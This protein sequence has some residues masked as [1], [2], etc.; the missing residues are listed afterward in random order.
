M[1]GL[2]GFLQA[3]GGSAETL[4]E[5]ASAM[6]DRLA[7]RGPDDAGAWVDAE[8]GIALGHRRLSIL[9]LTPEGHQPMLS[10]DGRYVV[11]FNG[12]VYNFAQLR[13]E[14]EEEGKAPAWRGHSDTEVL[15]AALCAWG[16][17]RTLERL[18]GMFAIALWDRSERTLTLVRDRMGEKPLYYGWA[19]SALL[20]GSELKAFGA[21]PAFR[22]EVDRGAL[23]LYLR[24]ACV[25][26]PFS[27]YRDVLKLPPACRVDVTSS[28]V[29]TK[30]L[31]APEPYWR[32]SESAAAGRRSPFPGTEAEGVAE[33]DRL[34][35]EAI[36]GQMVA[37]VPLGAFLS[38]GIDSSTVV[39]LM[40][41][42]SSRPVRTFSIGF[43]ESEYNEA[44]HARAVARH[45]GTEHT[46]LYVDAKEALAVVP[47]LRGIYDE[48]FADSSQIPTYLVAKLARQHVTVSLSGDGGDELFGGYNRY[49]WSE[50]LWGKLR[51]L[52][53]G[54]RRAL[55]RGAASVRPES[56]DRA[57]GAVS[58]LLPASLRYRSAGDKIHKLAG[59]LDFAS[60]EDLYARLVSFWREDG[61]VL[62]E[63]P[64][65]GTAWDSPD[66]LGGSVAEQ[67]ME[68]DMA[69][70]LPDDIL[71]KV[72]RAAMAVSLETRIPLL[73]HRV[74]EFALQVPLP[75]KMGGGRGK[76]I[77]RS[78]LSRYVPPAL[79]E[80]A[81]MGFSIP[82]DSWLRGPLRG[83][84]ETLLDERRLAQEGYL[85]AA[86][87][88]RRWEEHLSGARNWQHS[89]W[90][91]LM[92]QSWLE[93]QRG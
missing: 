5:L 71:V 83:W 11:A 91:V 40:Q 77:L 46:D 4:R 48:P 65:H 25:P 87:I 15:L 47:E 81:K 51:W 92:F 20:F 57:F 62:G 7:H 12:E 75:L 39:A 78:V 30:S 85:R 61:L 53:A 88:R 74:V 82:L 79:T 49:A 1:C 18:V 89:L 76:L 63:K 38:G 50:G 42:Q 14:L 60:V 27:I 45:L 84:A 44:E 34:L 36:A 21:H 17:A 32:L 69:G 90:A 23:A 67:M 56:W 55:A 86:P 66:T 35:R 37:D 80:R 8:A 22:P 43:R 10:A 24:Y 29:A 68:T 13:T 64:R 41:A 9:D 70:Y 16:I 2:T 19:G 31:P 3:P 93:G 59:L 6:A 28:H 33:L 52:P 54:V 73:D 72:D 26:Y 58:P